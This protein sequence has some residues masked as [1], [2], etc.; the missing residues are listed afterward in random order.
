MALPAKSAIHVGKPVAD[1]AT[2][3]AFVVM[4]ESV[5]DVRTDYKLLE[6]VLVEDELVEGFI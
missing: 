1:N 5:E 3:E 2:N 4:V 6:D